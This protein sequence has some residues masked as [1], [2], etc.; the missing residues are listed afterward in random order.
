MFFIIW[1]FYTNFIFILAY[2][3]KDNNNNYFI[4][5]SLA[6][7]YISLILNGY[8]PVIISFIS[9][10]LVIYHF[11]LK[12]MNNLYLF[13]TNETC[14]ECFNN[15]LYSKND[16]NGIFFLKFYTHIM[17]YKLD[18]DLNENNRDL[19]F[20]EAVHLN[21]TFFE[22]EENAKLF[23]A[24]VLHKVRVECKSLNNNMFTKNMFDEALQYAFN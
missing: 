17:K 8:L 4:F 2:I 14:Y 11:T 9:K 20:S 13:L 10:N 15:Y 6:V 16:V 19:G 23:D 22:N 21:N 3:N 18:F 5:A 1:V 12:L 24:E 7:L